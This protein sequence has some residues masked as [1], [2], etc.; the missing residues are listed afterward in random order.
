V[1]DSAEVKTII[2][3]SVLELNPL[4]FYGSILA[5]SIILIFLMGLLRYLTGPEYAFSI[6]FFI[7]IVVACWFVGEIPGYFIAVAS[8]VSWFVADM[9]MMDTFSKASIPIINESL[10]LVVFV[11]GVHLL[12]I[13]KSSLQV[14]K[15]LALTDPLTGIYNRRGFHQHATLEL[16]RF[17]RNQTPFSVLLIDIDNFKSI[18][19][20]YG[21]DIGDKLLVE[22]AKSV[23]AN[24]RSIDIYARM[25]GDEFV[26]L[27][28]ESGRNSP[29]VAAK[30]IHR[31]LTDSMEKK[32]WP[33]TFS[34]GAV[35]CNNAPGN[36]KELIKVA[37]KAMYTAKKKGKNK[38]EYRVLPNQLSQLRN[39][40]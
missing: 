35:I 17:R 4:L 2:Q 11:S 6:L 40:G 21:H 38:I 23:T 30:K 5:A 27:L 20:G 31:V 18:N 33:V 15:E 37:D 24:I 22:V 28:S 13:L 7:P 1:T 34:M 32:G 8:A 3:R 10:R 14:E 9:A 39:H 12:S 19:D 16:E 29:F 26:L 36:T 25:G